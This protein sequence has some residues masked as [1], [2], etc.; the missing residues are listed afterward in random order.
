MNMNQAARTVLLLATLAGVS[1]GCGKPKDPPPGAP[2]DATNAP[3]SVDLGP[4]V[5]VNEGT[6][7]DPT[8]P[9]AGS[10]TRQPGI[11]GQGQAPEESSPG[12]K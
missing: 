4:P 5:G 6:A 12:T 8:Q 2:A 11:S 10:T 1:T 3:P 9:G 7:S